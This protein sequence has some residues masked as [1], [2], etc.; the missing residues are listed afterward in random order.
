MH[1]GHVARLRMAFA[2]LVC[3]LAV[4]VVSAPGWAGAAEQARHSA[5]PGRVASCRPFT[6][7][8]GYSEYSGHFKYRASSV[9]RSAAISCAMTRKLLKAAYHQGPLRVVRTVYPFPNRSGRPIYWLRGGWRCSNGAGGASCWNAREPQFNAIPLEGLAH[10]LAV[11]AEV[12][13]AG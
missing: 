4:L 6:V 2:G 11:S 12:G 8:K 13:Y 9:E 7:F 10:G 1:L 5:D 3:A